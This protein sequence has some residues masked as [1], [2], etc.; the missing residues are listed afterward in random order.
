MKYIRVEG[1]VAFV[2][3]SRGYEAKIDAD[4]SDLVRPYSWHSVTIKGLIYARSTAGYMHRIITNCPKGQEVDHL[5]HD[6]LDNRRSNL[7]V[8]SHQQNM[9]N[10]F[11]ALTTKCP[12]GHPYNESNTYRN[13]K[14]DRICR[15]CNRIR[16]SEIYKSE[17]PEQREIRREKVKASYQK[18]L[19][20][21]R[22]KTREYAASHK[23]EKR[24]YD[25][26]RRERLR[27]R[28]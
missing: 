19:E 21:R 5:N 7:S 3:L 10:G 16:V 17:T 9:A 18:N 15:E 8:G 1:D 20:A 14:G 23:S 22:R 6:T 26:L 13:K 25:R 2:E 24:E 27:W 11:F 12:Q 28:Q 4:A